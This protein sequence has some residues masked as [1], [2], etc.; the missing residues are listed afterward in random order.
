MEEGSSPYWSLSKGER[1]HSGLDCHGRTIVQTLSN[2]LQV[3]V[4]K[5]S[6]AFIGN[7]FFFFG[8]PFKVLYT[9][10]GENAE[11]P[12]FL[13]DLFCNLSCYEEYRFRTS[14]RFIR[15]VSP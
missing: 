9:F 8:A 2:T 13:E 14:N 12:E 11:T 10:R 7:S 15:Q 1:I 4:A 6:F 5:C 3:S